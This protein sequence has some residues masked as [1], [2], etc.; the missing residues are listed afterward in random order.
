MPVGGGYGSPVNGSPIIGYGGP[1]SGSGFSPMSS[2]MNLL[3]LQR[4]G[5]Y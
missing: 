4:M 1:S 5:G 3:A 2:Y